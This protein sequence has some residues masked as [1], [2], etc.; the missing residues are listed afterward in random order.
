MSDAGD[1]PELGR[2]GRRLGGEDG[3]RLGQVHAAPPPHPRR[4]LQQARGFRRGPAEGQEGAGQRVVRCGEEE[5]KLHISLVS[6]LL[7][8]VSARYLF[9][10]SI[11]ILGHFDTY[12]Y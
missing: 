6:V 5:G 9:L 10:I 7:I 11:L 1:P 2:P 12:P 4:L 3:V 8:R